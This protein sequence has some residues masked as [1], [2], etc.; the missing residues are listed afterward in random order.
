MPEESL[1]MLISELKKNVELQ[2]KLRGAT[3]LDDAISIA[4]QAGYNVRKSDWLEFQ[5]KQTLELSDSELER[6]VGG[7]GWT[8]DCTNMIYCNNA[9]EYQGC[10]G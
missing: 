8:D 2:Q 9:S 1:L 3:D 4:Q 7:D 6:V 5:A 10:I